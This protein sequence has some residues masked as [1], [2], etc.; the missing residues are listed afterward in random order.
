MIVN[1]LDSTDFMGIP[2]L[3]NLTRTCVMFSISMKIDC[4]SD[5]EFAKG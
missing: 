5:F 1:H 4:I 2:K 3:E